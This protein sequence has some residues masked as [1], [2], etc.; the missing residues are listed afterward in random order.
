MVDIKYARVRDPPP[1]SIFFIRDMNFRPT[2]V[3]LEP[4]VTSI[5]PPNSTELDVNNGVQKTWSEVKRVESGYVK[6]RLLFT[7]LVTKDYSSTRFSVLQTEAHGTGR[8]PG[9]KANQT[10]IKDLDSRT[11]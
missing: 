7:L 9:D 4:H 1:F 8:R 10:S 5:E 3:S 2:L 6:K 11:L